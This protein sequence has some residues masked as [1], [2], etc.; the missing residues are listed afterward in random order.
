MVDIYL[1]KV[2]A[3]ALASAKLAELMV[4]ALGLAQLTS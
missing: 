2:S 4:G 3:A 1:V